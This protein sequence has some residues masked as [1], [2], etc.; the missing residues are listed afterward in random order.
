[1]SKLNEAREAKEKHK[2]FILSRPNVVGVGAG[3]KMT[4]GEWTEQVCV[5]AMVQTKVPL[6]DLSEENRIPSIVEDVATDVLEVGDLRALQ[7]RTER[8]RPAPPGVSLGHYSI[9]AGTFGC[10]V[11]D[12][13]TGERLILSNNHV[14]AN[15]NDAHEGDPILQPGTVDGGQT[16]ED[17]IATL[18]RFVPIHF[19][20]DTPPSTS[21]LPV[22]WLG[23][24]AKGLEWE[25]MAKKLEGKAVAIN[26]LVDAAVAKL[27]NEDMVLDE[28]LEIGAVR[29]TS[30]ITLGMLVRKSGR[31]T[32]LSSGKITIL[33]ST[34]SINYSGSRSARFDNQIL[35]TPM[36]Q[37]GDSGSLLVAEN[38]ELAVGLLF[39]GSD[40]VTIYNPIHIVL[41]KLQVHL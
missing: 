15:E 9:S 32:G 19:E 28:I 25:G 17:A 3:Y 6:E 13:Q 23:Q 5:V 39:A 21:C 7:D 34:V 29:G 40:L 11:R 16:G 12:R 2:D 20:G 18:L 4:A 35:T 30:A 14:L 37:G 24:V 33:D 22:E 10:I 36:S 41:D 26:N 27:L 31:S 38:T 8:W 1:M